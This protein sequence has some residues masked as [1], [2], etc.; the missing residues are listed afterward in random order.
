METLQVFVCVFNF[1]CVSAFFFRA[2]LPQLI[3]IRI[4]WELCY[5][6]NPES[7]ALRYSR[8]ICISNRIPCDADA[9]AQRTTLWVARKFWVNLVKFMSDYNKAGVQEA[10]PTEKQAR[11]HLWNRLSRSLIFIWA[12]IQTWPGK[13]TAWDLSLSLKPHARRWPH[14]TRLLAFPKN[15]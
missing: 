6:A 1:L 11:R 3:C 14:L 12:T 2:T 13:C 9:A 10:E 8:T 15:L 7:A 4:T 5:N